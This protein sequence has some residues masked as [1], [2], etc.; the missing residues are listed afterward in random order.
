MATFSKFK[1]GSEKELH[2]IIE[3]QLDALEEGLV[4]L[5]YE[6]GVGNVFL[7]SYV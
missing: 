5:K 3:S 1:P 4:L 6:M 7:I 2:S